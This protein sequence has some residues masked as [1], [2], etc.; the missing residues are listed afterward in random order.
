MMTCT[1]TKRQ[2]DEHLA[3]IEAQVGQVRAIVAA[4]QP[5]DA[6]LAI[7]GAVQEKL[8]TVAAAIPGLCGEQCELRL[9]SD[10]FCVEFERTF[11][12]QLRRCRRGAHGDLPARRAVSA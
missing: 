10:R 5:C 7:I 9:P 6:V 3:F 12:P 8:E 11:R 4:D 1:A 2:L